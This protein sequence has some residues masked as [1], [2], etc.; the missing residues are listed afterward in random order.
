MKCARSFS[1]NK[2][3]FWLHVKAHFVDNNASEE[4]SLTFPPSL[5]EGVGAPVDYR[6]P[7]LTG[8]Y[9]SR[10]RASIA[11]SLRVADSVGI[12]YAKRLI[13]E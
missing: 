8:R 1:V 6:S 13:E 12:E 2:Q 11:I 3:P 4:K 9:H 5:S 7:D 10:K